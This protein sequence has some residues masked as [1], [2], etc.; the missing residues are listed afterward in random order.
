MKQGISVM[1]KDFIFA[2]WKVYTIFIVYLVC[3]LKVKSVK[4]LFDT[5]VK[6]ETS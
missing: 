6:E 1:S 4:D 5:H 3:C 2:T